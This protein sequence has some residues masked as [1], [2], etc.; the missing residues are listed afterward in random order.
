MPARAGRADHAR[1]TS[2]PTHPGAAAI[3]AVYPER[4]SHALREAALRCATP[5]LQRPGQGRGGPPAQTPG[6]RATP[7]SQP[8]P[9]HAAFLRLPCRMPERKQARKHCTQGLLGVGVADAAHP[10]ASLAAR[11]AS[12]H[13]RSQAVPATH[14]D[15]TRRRSIVRPM[16]SP[17][18]RAQA[19]AHPRNSLA[20]RQLPSTNGRASCAPSPWGY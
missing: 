7:A 19:R 16:Q 6:A 4:A 14:I 2:T 8:R 20:H 17:P 13:R 5:A 15:D 10:Q 3:T 11:P 1:A 9:T 12:R 18:Q